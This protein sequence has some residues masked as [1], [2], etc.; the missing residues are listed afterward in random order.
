M[1]NKLEVD[2]FH[3]YSR[4]HSIIKQGREAAEA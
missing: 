2:H 4:E 3:R 1:K